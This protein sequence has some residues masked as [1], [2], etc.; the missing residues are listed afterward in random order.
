MV[1][2]I[3]A[4]ENIIINAIL[5]LDE[6]LD[7]LKRNAP[8]LLDNHFVGIVTRV[9]PGS[10]I[11]FIKIDRESQTLSEGERLDTP[12][13]FVTWQRALVICTQV[14]VWD[15]KHAIEQDSIPG[16]TE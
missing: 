8:R 4:N 7:D 14:I 9:P 13:K 12:G 11:T 5:P 10:G 2:E 15:R 6:G 16:S 3:D 1:Q